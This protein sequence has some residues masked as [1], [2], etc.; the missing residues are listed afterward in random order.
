MNLRIF[1]ARLSGTVSAIPSKSQAHRLLIC[2]AFADRETA[3]ICPETN[4]DIEATASCLRAL[5]AGILR[6]ADGYRI[7]PARDIPRK[8]DLFCGESGSTLRFLLP[9]AG[10]LGTDAR[11][12]MEGRLPERPLG[13]LTDEMQQM[14]CTLFR[15][16]RSVLRCRGRLEGGH[17]RIPGNISSQ[18]ITGL[19]F[20]LSLLQ[21]PCTLEI[22]GE[23]ESRPY[24]DMTLSVLS[25]FGISCKEGC[26]S[27]TETFRSPGTVRTEGDWSNAAFFLAAASMG[28]S[29]TV[30]GL[31]PD[32]LQGDRK[33]REQLSRLETGFCQIDGRDIPDLIPILSIAAAAH[34]GAVFKNI[35]RLRLKE[36]D[37]ICSTAAMLRSLG[38][39]CSETP[40]SLTVQ[41]G[42]FRSGTV[43]SF[44]DH[45]IAMA[46]ALAA[47]SAD[48]PVILN[49]AECVKKSYPRFWEDYQ[50]TGGHYEQYIR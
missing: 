2:S 39:R 17:Y 16:S 9:V 34:N 13:P 15:E 14:G 32:S 24:V 21:K 25:L 38:I 30:T 40:D 50:S 31:N 26:F 46:A 33:I 29:V 1:P 23:T 41:P 12:H 18:Y 49:G 20:A 8:A 27:G 35:S 22:L 11:F 5:G 4:A 48:G 36:S 19:L 6:T 10:A 43:D 7:T 45:R 37:R 3:L 42:P 44:G 28:H 47:A